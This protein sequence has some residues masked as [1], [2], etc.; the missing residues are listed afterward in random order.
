MVK[1]TDKNSEYLYVIFRIIIGLVFFLHGWMKLNSI[2]GG[3][4]DLIS[5]MG[6]A[7]IIEVLG[8]AFIVL[9]LFTRTTATI[10][11]L[12]MGYVFLIVHAKWIN[13]NPL[14]NKGEAAL[15]FFAA[16]LVII[17][18]GAGKYSIDNK[19]KGR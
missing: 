19:I 5:L 9:G 1:I 13:L 12:E 18:Y 11:A 6:L 14:A 10:T 4:M 3:K 16:F 15:L 7:M 8:G 2:I 17:A